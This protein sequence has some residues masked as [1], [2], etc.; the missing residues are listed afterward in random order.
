VTTA[1]LALGYPETGN[2]NLAGLVLKSRSW[3]IK[4]ANIGI[5]RF[6]IAQ[7]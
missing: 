5:V 6:L 7:F 4:R 1:K 2:F 3:R